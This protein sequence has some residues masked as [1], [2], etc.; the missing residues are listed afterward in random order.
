M[1]RMKKILCIIMSAMIFLLS[2]SAGASALVI[3]GEQIDHLPQVYVSGFES[4]KVYFKDDPAQEALFPVNYNILMENLKKFSEYTADT[5][6]PDIIYNYLYSAFY[7]TFS[8]NAFKGDGITNADDRVVCEPS[9]FIYEGDGF[10]YFTYDSRLS[11]IDIAKDLHEFIKQVQSHSGSE[12]FE[13]V[14]ASYG[15]TIVMTYLEMYPEMYTYIDSLLL[16]VPSYGGFSVIGEIYSGDFYID[17]DTLT[18][19]AYVGID[20]DDIGLLLSVLNKS[21]FLEI[22]LEKL[23]VPGVKAIAMRAARDVIH[24]TLGTIPSLW[25]FVGEEYFY[26]A[27]INIYGEDYLNPEHEYAGVIE[28]A[29]YYQENVMQKLDEI[30]LAA[31]ESGVKTNIICKYGRPP[32]PISKYGSFMSDGAVDV[33]HVTMGATASK[34]GETLPEDYEQALYP[35]YNYLSPDGCIDASTGID[36]LH[37]WYVRGLEH[38]QK[39]QGFNELIDYI[40]YEDPTVFSDDAF[41]Q[42]T[43]AM[44]DGS[45]APVTEPEEQEETSLLHDF[46]RLVIRLCTLLLEAFNKLIS[47]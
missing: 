39:N 27:M 21:G 18:Q 47:K 3:E 1:K 19:Y 22:F 41:P 6:D 25:T 9:E 43:K 8:M 30:Y 33:K 42:Y 45:L 10:Y 2:L 44:P 20:N 7:D 12:R 46:I 17:H 37:T 26:D 13:L 15:G 24:D 29:V 34:Y 32:M 36:P 11:P 40:V 35:E 16:S 4:R 23:L 5:T 31:K 38:T 28:K 14:G